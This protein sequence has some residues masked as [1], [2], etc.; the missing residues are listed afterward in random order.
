[1]RIKEEH[2]QRGE[3]EIKQEE[4]ELQKEED[5]AITEEEGN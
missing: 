3:G 4:D 1:M 2:N 5:W